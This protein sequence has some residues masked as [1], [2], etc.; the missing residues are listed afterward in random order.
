MGS[1]TRNENKAAQQRDLIS[2][3]T[4]PVE[5]LATHLMLECAEVLAG[6][7]PANLL[8]L[9]NR[10]RPCGRNLYQIWNQ[11]KHDLGCLLH[12]L[13]FLELQQHG[14][15]VLLLCF[16][17]Q[18]LERHLSHK[19]IRKLLSIAGYSPAES[20][21]QLLSKLADRVRNN[22]VFPH[23]IGMFIGYPAKDVAAFMGMI[24]LPF[25]C[26]GPW[27]IFGDPCKSLC[28]AE[29]FRHCRRQMTNAISTATAASATVHQ[30]QALFYNS[31]DNRCHFP[32]EQGIQ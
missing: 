17:R 21:D 8:P 32:D 9:V 20:L 16:S 29:Q 6:A 13:E 10:T 30:I 3:F 27:K 26:Q 24:K 1:I 4:D 2:S 15:S 28:L 18:H 31:I 23:E 11:H 25:T 19:G 12:N 5:C 14:R 7:K 22:G